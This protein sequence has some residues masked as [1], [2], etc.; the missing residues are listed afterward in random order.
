M[1]VAGLVV[2]EVEEDLAKDVSVVE[3]TVETETLMEGAEVIELITRML[4]M[5]L[6]KLPTE[7]EEKLRMISREIE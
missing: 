1:D 5:K 3:L 2:E 4:E 7:I 6:K